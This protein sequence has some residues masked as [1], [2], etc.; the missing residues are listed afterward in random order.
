M[1]PGVIV[2][3][4]L[5]LFQKQGVSFDLV[6]LLKFNRA[7]QDIGESAGHAPAIRLNQSVKKKI[8]ANISIDL[9][10]FSK[11]RLDSE[12]GAIYSQKTGAR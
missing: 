9:N 5:A 11:S 8:H 4:L 2:E 12:G 10:C 7:L 3:M 6:Q 1:F